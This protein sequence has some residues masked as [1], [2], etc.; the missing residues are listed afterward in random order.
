MEL[1]DLLANHHVPKK[2]TELCRKPTVWR[3]IH[4]KISRTPGK[5]RKLKPCMRRTR[6]HEQRIELFDRYLLVTANYLCVRIF[7]REIMMQ[8]ASIAIRHNPF[9]IFGACC[10]QRCRH[11]RVVWIKDDFL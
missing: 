9:L 11:H 3:Q 1:L 4:P 7:D 2:G 10:I 5:D 8:P 6:V